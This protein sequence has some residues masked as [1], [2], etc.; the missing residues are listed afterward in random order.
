MSS[1]HD[2]TPPPPYDD[3]VDG[4]GNVTPI[5]H[6]EPDH[7]RDAER[8]LLATLLHHPDLVEDTLD[9]LDGDEF[10]DPRH[11]LIWTAIADTL[12][13]DGIIPDPIT[14]LERLR[15]TGHAHKVAQLLPELATTNT[16]PLNL[17]AYVRIIR[18]HALRRRA[19]TD[20]TRALQ[21]V[22]TAAPDQ[23]HTIADA[24]YDLGDR[25]SHHAAGTRP[26]TTTHTDLA[27]LL[28]G[29]MPV[30]D[31]PT[32][33]RRADGH[34]TFYAARVNGIF[35]DPEAA[36]SWLAMVA[37]VEALTAGR[38]AAYIDVDH[39]GPAII[40]ERLILLGARPDH[41]ANPDLFQLHE[42]EDGPA[43]MAAITHLATWQPAVAVLDSIGEMMPMLGIKSVDN[44]ELSGALRATA[45]RLANT[46]T[47]V[48][49]VDHL[50]KGSES[51]GS[52][53]AIGGTAKKRA[54][55]GSYL[56][57]EARTEPAPGHIGKITLR[58]E[59]DRPGRLREHA[60][61]KYLGTF[62]IDSTTPG[63][64]TISIGDDSPITA[65]G[66]FRPTG[67]MEKVS[68]YVEERDN[69]SFNDIT[70][71]VSG[72]EENLRTAIK[73]LTD[74]GFMSTI[75]GPRR[76]VRH[77]VIAIYREADDDQAK[78]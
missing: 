32:Y 19:L 66:V 57:A 50:P 75:P 68:R 40:T 30:V 7:D 60:R 64:T 26:T 46:G 33:I 58:I 14:V 67:L 52:G 9:R 36:K 11:E 21:Q 34:A 62:T 70:E 65:A 42:P 18:D 61:G 6:R 8:A 3:H 4:A 71:H 51:R 31:P 77:H 49:T 48:I 55:D 78:H 29:Q 47:C 63:V 12:Q 5:R 54:I 39:N 23:H 25:I 27:W 53:F 74:E 13:T 35:G 22:E 43:L 24:L 17:S 41:L 76:S 38:R 37:V 16:N 15:A 2:D 73:R 72:K 59:K 44:D 45:T 1:V 20:L 28:T 56:H 10:Y 69:C